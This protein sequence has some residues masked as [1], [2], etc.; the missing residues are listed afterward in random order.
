MST[1]VTVEV[2][3]RVAWPSVTSTRI[4][5]SGAGRKPYDC[6]RLTTVDPGPVA[7][8]VSTSAPSTNHLTVSVSGS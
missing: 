6:V 1:T 3:S 8:S 4:A 7:V 2:H 5:C